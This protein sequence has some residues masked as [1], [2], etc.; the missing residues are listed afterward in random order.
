MQ[1]QK[2]YV[3]VTNW[4][5]GP[6]ALVFATLNLAH[7]HTIDRPQYE[8]T[9]M[10][11]HTGDPLFAQI[12]FSTG[13]GQTDSRYNNRQP[14]TRERERESYTRMLLMLCARIFII[15]RSGRK[16]VTDFNCLHHSFTY[17]PFI[18]SWLYAV[19]AVFELAN[20]QQTAPTK[21]LIW[22]R[23]FRRHPN[24]DKYK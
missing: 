23:I 13:Q 2:Y 1:N 7:T 21:V 20:E 17:H 5:V 18:Y 24:W 22:R 8:Y 12:T 15:S 11:H 9:K 4:L 3:Y 14:N 10:S 19:C 6:C 16:P